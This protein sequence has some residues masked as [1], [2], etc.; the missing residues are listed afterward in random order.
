MTSPR[1]P[2]TDLEAQIRRWDRPNRTLPANV[3]MSFCVDPDGDL[4]SINLRGL[5]DMDMDMARGLE[6]AKV[7]KRAWDL[8][9]AGVS[10]RCGT[11]RVLRDGKPMRDRPRFRVEVQYCGHGR[12]TSRW[13]PRSQFKMMVDLVPAFK[14]MI[15]ESVMRS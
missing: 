5:P 4:F 12:P 7:F 13:V 1:H 3:D 15:V 2:F 9:A 6:V 11:A 10:L 14:A 8:R